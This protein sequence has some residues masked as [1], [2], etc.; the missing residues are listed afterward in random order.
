MLGWLS[1]IAFHAVSDAMS[2]VVTYH[3]EGT[4]LSVD[5]MF[6]LTPQFSC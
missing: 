4:G 1:N 6:Y 5:F 3:V 2:M